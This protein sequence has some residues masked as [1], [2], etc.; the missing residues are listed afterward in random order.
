MRTKCTCSKITINYFV[1]GWLAWA[2]ACGASEERTLI[3][4][5]EIVL[6]PDEWTGFFF[7]KP[8]Y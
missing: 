2:F 4:R 5:E 1:G 8:C 7:F 3:A 6:V